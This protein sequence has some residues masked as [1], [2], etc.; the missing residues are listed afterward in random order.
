MCHAPRR[1]HRG[2]LRAAEG[3]AQ[4]VMWAVPTP[5]RQQQQWETMEEMISNDGTLAGPHEHRHGVSR[6]AGTR[7]RTHRPVQTA[8][9]RVEGR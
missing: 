7:W 4:R 2:I 8:A 1:H 3:G 9:V 6:A 5:K